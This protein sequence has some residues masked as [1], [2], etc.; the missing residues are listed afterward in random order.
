MKITQ[1]QIRKIIQE[2]IAKVNEAM[3]PREQ[4]MAI[5]KDLVNRRMQRADAVE[6]LG[7]Y[8]KEVVGHGMGRQCS[9]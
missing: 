4:I 1:S 2:E 6:E 9:Q 5:A 7:E 8:G 3:D